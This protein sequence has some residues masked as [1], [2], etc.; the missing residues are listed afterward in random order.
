LVAAVLFLIIGL[1]PELGWKTAA[2][3]ICG[4]AFPL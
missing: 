2:A 3:F 4:A 1:I